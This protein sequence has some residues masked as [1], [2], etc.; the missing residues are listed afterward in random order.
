V[1]DA[2]HQHANAFRVKSID[3]SV[4]TDPQPMQ[5]GAFASH[6]N[7]IGRSGIISER[8]NRSAHTILDRRPQ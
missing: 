1:S 3:D 8:A 7:R 5:T 4:R 6:R 2:D